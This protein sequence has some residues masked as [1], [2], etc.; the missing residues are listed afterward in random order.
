MGVPYYYTHLIKQHNQILKE[1]VILSKNVYLFIDAN[2]LIY[3]NCIDALDEDAIIDGVIKKIKYLI[4]EC[5]SKYTYIAFDGL[6]PFAKIEQQRTRRY[7]SAITK[8]ILGNTNTNTITKNNN[9]WDTCAITP[10]TVF[11]AKVNEKIKK[12]FSAKTKYYVSGSDDHGEGEHKIFE[13]IRTNKEKLATKDVILYGLDADLIMLSLHHLKYLSNIHLYRET[14]DFIR[15]I[16]IDM[17]PDKKY[18]MDI[19]EL[20]LIIESN[21][22]AVDDYLILAFFMGNDFLPHFPSLNIRKKGLEKIINLK[23]KHN[24]NL[25]SEN[26]KIIWKNLRLI[27]QELA[28]LERGSMKEVY[29]RKIHLQNYETRDDALL[30]IPTIDRTL[31][32][33]INPYN[34][35]WRF[36]YYKQLF[37]I[38]IRYNE[39][40][41]CAICTNYIEGLEWTFKYYSGCPINYNWHYKY[42]YPPL[43]EDL[44]NYIPFYEMEYTKEAK[45]NFNELMQLSY[46]LPYDSLHLLPKSIQYKLN[47]D[48]YRTDCTIIWAYC[49]YFWESHVILPPIDVNKLSHIV[50][51]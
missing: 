24:T 22:I 20:S 6:P 30:N 33:S 42:E 40:I 46:V 14:P 1:F 41:I 18:L 31:E 10:G 36:N 39:E 27:V 15:S 49:K 4:S 23:K 26:G 28:I 21:N 7:K 34:E 2:S 16:N 11:M 38:D 44:I 47:M 8:R 48:W 29:D 3:D 45:T 17:D 12:A 43:F 32:L 51:G 37:D 50:N 13:Y 9:K 19:Y 35:D 5:N 25:I